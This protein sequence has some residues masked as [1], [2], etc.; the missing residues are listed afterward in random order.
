M[1]WRPH[2]LLDG[3]QTLP[4]KE[5]TMPTIKIPNKRNRSKTNLPRRDLEITTEEIERKTRTVSPAVAAS[6][7]MAA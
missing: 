1:A 5:P 6:R 7:C 3:P 2:P 4:E